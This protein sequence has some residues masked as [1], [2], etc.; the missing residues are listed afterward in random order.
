[1]L[2]RITLR[3]VLQV[4]LVASLLP[5]VAFAQSQDTQSVAEASRRAR[6]QKK[7]PAKPAKV[8]TDEDIK[9][10]PQPG[11]ATPAVQDAT[12]ASGTASSATDA[13]AASSGIAA[14]TEKPASS[15]AVSDAEEKKKAKE[16]AELKAKI[17]EAASDVDLLQ[18]EQ[19]LEN[20]SYYSNTD[21]IHDTAGKAKLDD[22][23]QQISDK[24]Q[25]LE[26]LKAHLLELQPSQPGAP[27]KP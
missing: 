18:R 10:A 22:L 15:P 25:E 14:S 12:A 4:V 9:P 27:P 24:Q 16:L 13:T 17:K 19:K 1:M 21:Y 6:E 7:P 20:D 11:S 26:R 23:K 8:I 2:R 3:L 5:A